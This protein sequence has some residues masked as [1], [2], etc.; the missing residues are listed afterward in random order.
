LVGG[1]EHDVRVSSHPPASS[2]YLANVASQ[3]HQF[4]V[5]HFRYG[6]PWHGVA[7]E[8]EA[9]WPVTMQK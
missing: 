4:F 9:G 6:S 8:H 7:S 2:K 1:F 5:G 3:T